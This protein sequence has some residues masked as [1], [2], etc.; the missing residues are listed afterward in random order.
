MEAPGRK[1]R[2][3]AIGLEHNQNLI[4]RKKARRGR[5]RERVAPTER[6]KENDSCFLEQ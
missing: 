4:S 6:E 3:D 1:R 5:E 2:D